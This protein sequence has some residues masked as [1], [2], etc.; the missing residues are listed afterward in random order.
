LDE[1]IKEIAWL[2]VDFCGNCGYC[3]GGRCKMIFGKEFTN[4][5]GTTF[6]FTDPDVET[7]GC[8][9]KLVEIRKNG[10]LKR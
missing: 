1:N 7:L 2:N 6:R 5:C 10:I 9:K 8:M 4:V 3:T